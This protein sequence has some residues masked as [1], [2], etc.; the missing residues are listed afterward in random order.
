MLTNIAS[1][2]SEHTRAVLESG[3][4]PAFVQ[5]AQENP[6]DDDRSQVSINYCDWNF[7]LRMLTYVIVASS[8]GIG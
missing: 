5:L 1:G 4:V 6:A 7:C 2:T 3:A 8:V